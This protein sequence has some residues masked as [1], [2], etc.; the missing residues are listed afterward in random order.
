[1]T[2]ADL[3]LVTEGIDRVDI[4]LMYDADNYKPKVELIQV[5]QDS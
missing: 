3:G 2:H 1:M 5:A 4:D